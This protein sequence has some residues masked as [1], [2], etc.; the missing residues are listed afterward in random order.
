MRRFYEDEWLGGGEER[1][2][3]V[4]RQWTWHYAMPHGQ[5][6]HRNGLRCT[7]LSQIASLVAID[8]QAKRDVRMALLVLRRLQQTLD[9]TSEG[10]PAELVVEILKYLTSRRVPSLHHHHLQ[11]FSSFL[12]AQ[13]H[14]FAQFLFGFV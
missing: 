6:Y 13:V 9:E 7:T 1:A 4:A 11:P 2:R 5:A 3:E 10:L 12:L 14:S 8:S